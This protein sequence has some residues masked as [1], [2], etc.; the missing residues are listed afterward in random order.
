MMDDVDDMEA[1]TELDALIAEK[2]MGWTKY[3]YEKEGTTHTEWTEARSVGTRYHADFH[4]STDI[5]TAWDVVE[6][7]ARR[8]Y[9]LGRVGKEF[10]EG[11]Y[12]AQFFHGKTYGQAC[13][14]ARGETAPLAICRAAF[15]AIQSPVVK[16]PAP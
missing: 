4:P 14:H 1:G 13:E 12:I 2:V 11:Q 8:G 3:V 6:E 9:D 7:L 16:E 5:S 15:K 10:G